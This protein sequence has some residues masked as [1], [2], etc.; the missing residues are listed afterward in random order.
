MGPEQCTSLSTN[1]QAVHF[2]LLLGPGS[3]SSRRCAPM[4]LPKLFAEQRGALRCKHQFSKC[5]KTKYY[6][7]TC[8][9]RRLAL[10]L[11]LVCGPQVPPRRPVAFIQTKDSVIIE[12]TTGIYS[13][14]LT[15]S[16][17]EAF[18]WLWRSQF[19]VG[20]VLKLSIQG[21]DGK[22]FRAGMVRFSGLGW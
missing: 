7:L 1:F 21:W 13:S 15:L 3:S 19:S 18:D 6:S 4:I 14:E 9:K 2:W 20:H 11:V 8:E 10:V 17:L 22:T 16:I 5:W 12:S